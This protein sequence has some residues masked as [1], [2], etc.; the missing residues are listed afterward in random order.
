MKYLL[1]TNK[2]RVLA[3]VSALVASSPASAVC[4]GCVTSAV[5]T[6][7]AA[8]VT[9]VAAG[10]T[11][12][13]GAILTATGLL[14]NEIAGN[15]AAT[16]SAVIAGVGGAVV[17][18][19]EMVAES[20]AKLT[21]RVHAVQAMSRGVL[22]DPC[23]AVAG[24][25]KTDQIGEIAAAVAG[26]MPGG[27]AGGG[28]GAQ[29]PWVSNGALA[30]IGGKPSP[31]AK[32]LSVALGAAAAPPPEELAISASQFGCGS[33]AVQGSTRGKNCVEAD[34]PLW[35]P[36]GNAKR[37]NADIRADTLF[38]GPQGDPSKVVRRR[39][40]SGEVDEVAM[41]ALMRNLVEPLSFRDLKA[42]ETRS[43][44]GRRYLALHDSYQA[45]LAVASQ[46]LRDQAAD[47]AADKATIPFLTNLMENG[48]RFR[49]YTRDFL[50]KIKNPSAPTA[51]YSWKT[52][53]IG[54]SEYRALE[55]NRRYRNPDWYAFLGM[56]SEREQFVEMATMA[57]TQ[58]ALQTEM[59]DELK[60]TR[61]ALSTLAATQVRAEMIPALARQHAA[62]TR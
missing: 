22:R 43:D 1:K 7:G 8:T 30:S 39:T 31:G 9:T 62:A 28:A 38:Y 26:R 32:V 44:E 21:A 17:K 2:F 35:T 29:L 4:D 46:G 3:A 60:L 23:A 55:A 40:I 19:A 59:I 27:S 11:A 12:I 51:E 50:G 52:L 34:G 24:A 53:G 20:D 57:A 14:M 41:A 25:A 47:L 54:P 13:T 58:I 48:N 15:S 61:V 5:T 49:L 18:S 6:W 16:S 42:S 36:T 45:K 10:T 33:F 56:A 37:P